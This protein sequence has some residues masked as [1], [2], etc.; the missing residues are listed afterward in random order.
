MNLRL[1]SEK[2]VNPRLTICAWCGKDVSVALLGAS[3]GVYKC[4]QCG[5]LSIGGRPGKDRPG[6]LGHS[7]CPKCEATDSYVLDRKIADYER[8]NLGELCDECL[9]KQ[10]E[11]AEE[12][13]RGGIYWK[14]SVCGSSSVIKAE[15]SLSGAVRKKLG[16]EVPNPCGVEFDQGHCPVCRGDVTP[17][18]EVANQCPEKV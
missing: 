13:A 5:Q 16:I 3:D 8:L 6:H 2:G 18:E 15:H 14:C 7:V 17:P 4:T 10:K 9:K 11:H 1:H 12:V